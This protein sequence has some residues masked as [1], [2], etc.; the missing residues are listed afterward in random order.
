ME[1]ISINDIIF[2]TATIRG[3]IAA[4]LRLSGLNSMAEVIAAIKKELGF[5]GGLLTITLRNMTQGWCWS[6]SL[7]L[8]PAPIRPAIG[9][10][11]TLF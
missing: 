4:T 3:S 9:Q 8:T 2:A 6:K 10:Q 1:K 7:Y 11:L 5:V